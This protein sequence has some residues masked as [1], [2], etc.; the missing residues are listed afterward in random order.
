MGDFPVARHFGLAVKVFGSHGAG[1]AS[2][3]VPIH[4]G[5]V[6]SYHDRPRNVCVAVSLDHNAD[7]ITTATRGACH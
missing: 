2:P 3:A 7:L 6:F 4:R 5:P 1:T